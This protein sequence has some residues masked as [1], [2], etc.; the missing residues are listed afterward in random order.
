MQAPLQL[1]RD[2]RDRCPPSIRSGGSVVS[3]SVTR[4]FAAPPSRKALVLG[5]GALGL[6]AAL[7]SAAFLPEGRAAA[8]AT[9]AR[10]PAPDEVLAKV[11][12]RE[13][14][15]ARASRQLAASDVG[16]RVEL[17]RRWMER[18]RLRSDPRLYGRAQAALAPWGA[19]DDAPEEVRLLRAQLAQA[20]HDFAS[21]R[22]DFDALAELRPQDVAVQL[23]RAAVATVTADYP[24]ALASCRALAPAVPS[25]VA[26]ACEAPVRLIRGEA[27]LAYRQLGELAA[28][29]T[30]LEPRVLAWAEGL[31]GELAASF[32]EDA[33][34]ERHLRAA[35]AVTGDPYLAVALA[36][37][38]LAKGRPAEVLALATEPEATGDGL[39][40]RVAI[41]QQR[42]GAP[43]AS[44]T[45]AH[46]RERLA[47]TSARGDFTHQR[48]QGLFEL[49]LERRPERALAHLLANW[50]LQREPID[51]LLLLRAATAAGR[52][53]AAEPVRQWVR[54]HGVRDRAITAAL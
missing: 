49:E 23:G 20:L 39:L 25:L 46:L 12:A 43:Q 24:A 40:L 19:R 7:S 3:A 44:A 22:R 33:A 17:A 29:S 45:V 47:A 34:A 51:A 27:E 15:A 11:D 8:A 1:D 54:E 5:L 31:R 53:E 6:A 50:Q 2:A 18:A 37:L 35:L 38:L 10:Q 32:G 16:A 52:P 41:A 13:R 28:Q 42:L 21:A 30:E 36:D 9:A 48:E 14:A 4:S 26:A